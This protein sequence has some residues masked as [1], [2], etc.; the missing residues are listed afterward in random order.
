MSEAGLERLLEL[1]P[2]A[3]VAVASDGQIVM[4]NAQAELLFGYSRWEPVGERVELLVP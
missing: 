3:T 2:D 1:V 4:V